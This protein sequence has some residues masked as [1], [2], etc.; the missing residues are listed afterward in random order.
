MT[1]GARG[2]GVR[3]R[4]AG[5][6]GRR[7]DAVAAGAPGA[8]RRRVPAALRRPPGPERRHRARRGRGLPR[9]RPAR[10]RR[11]ARGLRPRHVTGP[12]GDH[13]A[14]PDDPARRRAQPARRRGRGRRARGL[15]RLLAADRGRRRDDRQ[16]RRGGAGRVRAAPRPRRLHPELHPPRD[17]G[18]RPRR[19]SPARSS[20]RTGSA[21][22]PVWPTPSTRARR[23]PRPARRSARPSAPAPCWSP[24]PWSPSARRGRC[25]GG[26]GASRERRAGALTQAR[27]VRRDPVPRGDRAR[28]DD[29][30]DDQPGA[31]PVA[32]RRLRSGSASASPAWCWPAC[33]G[34]RRRTSSAG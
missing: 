25:S 11:R 2:S 29:P 24:A 21:S 13:P 30:G 14:Q 12:A 6:R 31:R 19:A 7:P 9:R 20:A 26:A 15:L 1:P 4:V 23:W 17:A 18:G 3:R 34:G 10:G 22:R 27:D 16:G 28:P 5:A 32:D 33:C 8:V